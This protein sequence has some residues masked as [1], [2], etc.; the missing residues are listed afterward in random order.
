[1]KY[2]TMMTMIIVSL[3]SSSLVP[4][5]RPGPSLSSWSLI[6][7][8][9]H[10]CPFVGAGRRLWAV[11][12]GGSGPWWVVVVGRGSFFGGGGRGGR[13]VIGHR[14]GHHWCGGSSGGGGG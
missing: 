8:L 3:S 12:G 7:G 5:H 6:V 1:M 10:L 11:V 2:K 4:H 13:A 14:W 9:H